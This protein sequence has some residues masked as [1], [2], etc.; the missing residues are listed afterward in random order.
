MNGMRIHIAAKN[1]NMVWQDAGIVYREKREHLRP[2]ESI[3]L[4]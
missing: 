2:G 1:A 4:K 3:D